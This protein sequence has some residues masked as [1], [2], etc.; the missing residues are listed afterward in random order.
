LI[1]SKLSPENSTVDG[2]QFSD[3]IADI[4]ATMPGFSDTAPENNLRQSPERLA[5]DLAALSE[6]VDRIFRLFGVNINANR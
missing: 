1:G 6:K 4:I 3:T 2:Q 5:F